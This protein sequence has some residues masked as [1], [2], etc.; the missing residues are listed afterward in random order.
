MKS[1]ISIAIGFAILLFSVMA[2]FRTMNAMLVHQDATVY[3]DSKHCPVKLQGDGSCMLEGDYSHSLI[4]DEA[5]IRMTD[6]RV[7]M[8]PAENV[9]TVMYDSDSSTYEPF[10]KAVAFALGLFILIGP[11]ALWMWPHVARSTN[12]ARSAF[13]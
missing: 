11:F 4:Q 8:V 13:K 6:G 1:F 7:W 3:F 2:S 9:R 10:G 5:T 12:L